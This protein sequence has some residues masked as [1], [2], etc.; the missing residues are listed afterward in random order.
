V[1][2]SEG[3]EAAREP[4][5]LSRD[6]DHVR[7][8]TMNRPAKLNAFD[9]ALF[10]G[11]ADALEAA[12]ADDE[13]RVAVLTGA[14]R[15]FSAGADL[16]DMARGGTSRDGAD[17]GARPF[18]RLLQAAA[19]FPK[20]LVAAVNGVGVGLG[21]TILGHCD[22]TFIARS[23]RLRTPFIQLGLSPEASSTFMFPL[24][25]GWQNAACALLAGEWF[26]AQ[27]AVDSGLA[28]KVCDDDVVLP[29]AITFA[30]QV[31][32]GPLESLVATKGLMLDAYRDVVAQTH[33]RETETLARLTGG[34]ANQA[35]LRAF[36]SR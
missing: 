13:V 34:P 22:F 36:H 1:A 8:L 3:T 14:G 18:D 9:A 32:A 2:E 16:T 26:D 31:A 15:A 33:R 25:M 6:A 28:L 20:P 30:A 21:F 10:A 27:R 12:A 23:A 24:R 29:T 17:V 7:V 5:V 4:V 19:S 35:A 11:L